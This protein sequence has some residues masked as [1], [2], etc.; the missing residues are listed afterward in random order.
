[1]K[2]KYVGSNFNG[3]LKHHFLLRHSTAVAQDRILKHN[4]DADIDDQ[5]DINLSLITP[6]KKSKGIRN[7]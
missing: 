5:S 7:P 3:F 6:P 1:M 2:K 4:V